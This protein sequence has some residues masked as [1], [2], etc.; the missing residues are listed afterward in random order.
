[1]VT[2]NPEDLFA[3][4]HNKNLLLTLW[5]CYLT[6]MNWLLNRIKHCWQTKQQRKKH[7]QEAEF[8]YTEN[9]MRFEAS[10]NRFN[11]F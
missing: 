2:D 4:A 5:Y 3:W 8:L 9:G 11:D 6:I 7:K 1:M 10:V